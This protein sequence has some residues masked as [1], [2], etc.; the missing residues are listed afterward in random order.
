MSTLTKPTNG[1]F[2]VPAGTRLWGEIITWDCAGII[3]KHLDLID[4]LRASGLEESVARELAPRHAFS[5][6]CKKLS[7]ARIIRQVSEDEKL[8]RF[9]FTAEHR[10]GDRFSY[11]LET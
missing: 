7:E 10:E 8:I 9:Q 6:A 11:D 3:I 2:Q 5:R 4:A 1:V